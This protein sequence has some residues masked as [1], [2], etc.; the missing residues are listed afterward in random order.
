MAKSTGKPSKR[1]PIEAKRV[2]RRLAPAGTTVEARENQI[3][4]LA[5]DLVEQRIRKG[6]ATSQEVTQFIKMG[7]SQAQLEREKLKRENEF[8]AAKAE[9]L[10]SQKRVEELYRTAMDAFKV[11]SGQEETDAED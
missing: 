10:K 8:L 4:R 7:S 2:K 1:Q 9:A 3:I 11:Y 6:T 5:Y